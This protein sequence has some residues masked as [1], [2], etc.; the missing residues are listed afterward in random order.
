MSSR[1]LN[2]VIGRPGGRI[3]RVSEWIYGRYW[4]RVA[5]M[6]NNLFGLQMSY[7][8]LNMFVLQIQMHI[9]NMIMVIILLYDIP[10][11]LYH[12]LHLIIKNAILLNPMI[13]FLT[14]SSTFCITFCEMSTRFTSRV[15]VSRN[16]YFRSIVSK[17]KERAAR[18]R[19]SA[20]RQT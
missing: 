3:T 6:C 11:Q 4:I 14:K 10:I 16:W 20:S 5:N 12:L 8:L 7:V 19:E 9:K 1:S 17:Y 18:M 2:E 15:C 13:T